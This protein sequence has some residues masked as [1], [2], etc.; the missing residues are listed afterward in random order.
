MAK[1]LERLQMSSSGSTQGREDWR[2]RDVVRTL[3]E[4]LVKERAK[5][6]RSASKRCQ[7]QRLL[8]EQV[9]L[10]LLTVAVWK[11]KSFIVLILYYIHRLITS[12]HGN[13]LVKMC[14]NPVF[15][16]FSTV[17]LLSLPAGGAEGI[18]VRSPCSCQESHQRAGVTTER[19]RHSKRVLY[20]FFLSLF[21]HSLTIWI[22]KDQTMCL[23]R[24]FSLCQQQSDSSVRS[25]QLSRRQ[26]NLSLSLP[27]EEAGIRR[28]PGSLG[29]QR[30]HAGQSAKVRRKRKKSRFFRTSCSH[31]QAVALSHRYCLC[32]DCLT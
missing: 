17:S 7:E 14:M 19:V 31:T 3:E 8:V 23:D 32:L 20:L 27:R 15:C 24:L 9:D 6:Q 5:S 13:V 21:I 25:R 30:A 11:K 28:G 10:P 29:I 22:I 18:R 4:Q 1:V 2:V 26:G 12:S 16:C